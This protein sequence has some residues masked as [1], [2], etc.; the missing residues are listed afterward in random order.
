MLHHIHEYKVIAKRCFFLF[1]LGSGSS[2]MIITSFDSCVQLPLAMPASAFWVIVM[3]RDEI[4]YSLIVGALSLPVPPRWCPKYCS[5]L[6]WHSSLSVNRNLVAFVVVFCREPWKNSLQ[7]KKDGFVCNAI[8]LRPALIVNAI[9]I[10]KWMK[11]YHM[12][13]FNCQNIP[14][15]LT[16]CY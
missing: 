4:T 15:G 3:R 16:L 8:I 5:R 6:S 12:C 14:S 11:P 9:I 10:V 7:E 13:C 1:R 2:L